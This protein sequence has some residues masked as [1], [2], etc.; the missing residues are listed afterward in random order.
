MGGGKGW[1][2][3]SSQKDFSLGQETSQISFSNSTLLSWCQLSQAT[4]TWL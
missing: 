1:L 3:L 2:T 4:T